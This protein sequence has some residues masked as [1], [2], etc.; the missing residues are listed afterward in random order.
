MV[1]QLCGLRA[2]GDLTG[3]AFEVRDQLIGRPTLP[4]L[5][6]VE[7]TEVQATIRRLQKEIL[8]AVGFINLGQ[9][10]RQQGESRSPRND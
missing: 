10:L 7:I 8:I 3:S 6:G 1:L 5:A 9:P 4:T 2:R